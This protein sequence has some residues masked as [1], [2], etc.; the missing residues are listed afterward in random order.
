MRSLIQELGQPD[1]LSDNDRGWYAFGLVPPARVERPGIAPEGF[2]VR[3]LTLS[4]LRNHSRRHHRSHP[5]V[6]RVI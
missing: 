4:S 2:H 1:L 5:P 3:F 6:L